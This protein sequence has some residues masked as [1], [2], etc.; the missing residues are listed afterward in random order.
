[1]GKRGEKIKVEIGADTNKIKR[2][3]KEDKENE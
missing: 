2:R 1:M 3:G